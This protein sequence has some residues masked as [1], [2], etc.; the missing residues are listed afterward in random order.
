MDTTGAG[1]SFVGAT[2]AAWAA[3][4]DEPSAL[5]QAV[6]AGAVAVG[7]GGAQPTADLA[8]QRERTAAEVGLRKLS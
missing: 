5:T 1:D 4:P 6:A 8:R 2:A 3:A 7:H